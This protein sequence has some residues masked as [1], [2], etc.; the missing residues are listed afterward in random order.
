[1]PQ[2]KV[3]HLWK[4]DS[5]SRGG[6]GAVS[7]CRLHSGLRKAGIDSKILCQIKNTQSPYIQVLQRQT[8]V[9]IVE[10]L[11]E[12]ITTP[13][14]LKSEVRSQKSEINSPKLV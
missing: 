12:Q 9:K 10:K 11:L 2:M 13:F 4:S 7:M 5:S 14:G 1:M 6:G 8:S 3:V